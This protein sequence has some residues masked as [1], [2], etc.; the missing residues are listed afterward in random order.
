[1][2]TDQFVAAVILTATGELSTASFGDDDYSKV[3]QLG[4][5]R[6]DNWAREADW[7]SLYDPGVDCGTISATDTFDLDD[8]IR[9]I[10]NDPTDRVQ[11]VKTD[12]N[13]TQYETV[14]PDRLKYYPSGHYCAKVGDTLVFN[15]AFT[16]DSPEYG[17]TLKV[18]AFLY[19]DHLSKA[20]DTVPVDDPNWLVN[21]TA[22]DWA[23]TDL[24]LSQNVPQLVAQA[25][26]LMDS[27]KKNSRPQKSTV[28]MSNFLGGMR[29]F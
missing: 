12:G 7:A 27:M 28:P 23:M 6:I 3:V 18:P 21:I 24:T 8:S 1:M 20:T 4:N 29:Q 9:V 17:G 11:I 5:I 2:T 16:S 19:A 13:V 22:A 15:Q 10:S 26:D 14:S 25:N